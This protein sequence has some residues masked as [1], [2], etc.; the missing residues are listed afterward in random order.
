MKYYDGISY[1]KPDLAALLCY[2]FNT[3][4]LFNGWI[5]VNFVYYIHLYVML[6]S[7]SM[8]RHRKNRITLQ[9]SNMENMV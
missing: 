3:D 1:P 2:T 6:H 7:S 8:T 4:F 5:P 9:N